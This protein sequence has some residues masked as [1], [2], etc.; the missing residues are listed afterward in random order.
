MALAMQT[1]GYRKVGEA[2]LVLPWAKVISL[3]SLHL[4]TMRSSWKWGN[5]DLPWVKVISLPYSHQDTKRSSWKEG[6]LVLS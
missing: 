1:A 4:D 6:T 2:T 5:L 3:S